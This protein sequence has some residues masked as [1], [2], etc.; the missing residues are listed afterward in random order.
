[1]PKKITISPPFSFFD[2]F[3]K[4]NLGKN[5]YQ[6]YKSGRYSLY[7]GL[8]NLLTFD[9]KINT[10]YVPTLICPQ[11]LIP[12][13]K[14]G[15]NI[16]YY[17]IDKKLGIDKKYLSSV[18]D[19][20]CIVMVINYFGFPSDWDFFNNIK[21]SSKCF[22]I[23]DNCHSMFTEYNQK[24]IDSFGDISF[25]SMRKIVPT[26]SGSQLFYNNINLNIH[27]YSDRP[28]NLNKSDL[29]SI[30]RPLK[31]SFITKKLGEGEQVGKYDSTK[32][33][34]NFFN[35]SNNTNIDKVSSNIYQKYLRDEKSIRESRLNNYIAWRNFLPESDFTFFNDNSV[36]DKICPYVFP[37]VPKSEKIMKK[38]LTWSRTRNTVVINWGNELDELDMDLRMLLFFPVAQ[39]FDISTIAN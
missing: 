7:Y 31:P 2:I 14:L 32:S 27:D 20:K 5:D 38:W 19:N 9:S 28:R 18:V 6:L 37:C 16:K 8:K 35:I 17:N 25:N 29:I 13:D 36:D 12:I 22:L 33:Y 10:I 30:L 11:V 23:S 15:L 21:D 34:D 1:M 39:N 4:L 24:K 26:L 3:Y